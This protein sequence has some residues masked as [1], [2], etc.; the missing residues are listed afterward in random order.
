MLSLDFVLSDIRT[1]ANDW[2]VELSQPEDGS[3]EAVGESGPGLRVSAAT[4]GTLGLFLQ[5]FKKKEKRKKP[6]HNLRRV[7]QLFRTNTCHFGVPVLVLEF[8]GDSGTPEIPRVKVSD[9]FD[10]KPKQVP[11]EAEAFVVARC[12]RRKRMA[13]FHLGKSPGMRPGRM[14]ESPATLAND[15]PRTSFA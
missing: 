15:I 5:S 11:S 9:L 12:L 3:M 2:G 14:S 4:T 7:H 10:Q 1:T 6:K 8:M 13:C